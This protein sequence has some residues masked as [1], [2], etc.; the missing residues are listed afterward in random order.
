MSAHGVRA[1]PRRPPG[2]GLQRAQLHPGPRPPKARQCRPIGP[3]PPGARH[4]ARRRAPARLAAVARQ[5]PRPP[6][7]PLASHAA[8]A[9]RARRRPPRLPPLRPQPRSA[10]GWG[11]PIAPGA[12]GLPSA[13]AR[14]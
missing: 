4:G 2:T 12:P 3:L 7:P 10:A 9:A 5:A 6:G 13:H 11:Y 8:G 1:Q 14:P